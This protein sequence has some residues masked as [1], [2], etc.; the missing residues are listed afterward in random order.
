V[1]GTFRQQR[2]PR[3]AGALVCETRR[4]MSAVVLLLAGA[5]VAV[6]GTWQG[7]RAAASAL[8]PLMRKGDPTRT[9]IDASRPVHARTR[10]RVMARHVVLAVAWVAVAMY[11]LFLATVGAQGMR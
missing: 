2:A 10:V 3:L 8:L 11:G 9:L 6:W 4:V 1:V 7:Y 5:F